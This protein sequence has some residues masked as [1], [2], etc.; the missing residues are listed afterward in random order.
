MTA[1]TG[2]TGAGKSIILGALG[3]VLGDRADRDVVRDGCERADI[4]AEFDIGAL[5]AALAWLDENTLSAAP[6]PAQCLIRRTVGADGRSRSWINNTPVTLQA[7]AALGEL[8]MDI[9]SQHEHHSLLKKAT[10]QQLLD[11][12]AGHSAQV[13]QLRELAIQWRDSHQRLQHLRDL[14]AEQAALNELARYQLNELEELQLGS[15][16]LESLEKELD[17]LAQADSRLA[18]I[19]SLLLICREQDD[20]N[21]RQQ[22]QQALHLLGQLT[23]HKKGE[24][25]TGVASQL[26]SVE[27]MLNTAL[28]QVEEAADEMSRLA[29][30]I[31]INPAR[32]EQLNRRL[33]DIH[34]LA[35]KHKVRPD[36]LAGL[37]HRLQ[38]QLASVSH[39]AD[40]M[41]HLELE[42][43]RLHTAW[44]GLAST[45]SQQ[46]QR[47]ADK[48]GTAVN[49]Q[50]QALAMGEASLTVH[51]QPNESN[52]PQAHGLEQ[53]EFLISTNRGQAARALSKIASGGELSRI[54]LAIQVITAMTS[55]IPCLVFDEVDV[56]IG[57]AVARTVGK[58]LRQLGERGQVL[59]VTHQALVAGQAHQHY[60]VSKAADG[61]SAHSQLIE[62]SNEQRTQE[63]ARMLGGET[64]QGS[65]S[66]ESMAHARELLSA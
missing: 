30:R 32:L 47:A 26:E 36:E 12:F 48:L 43:K 35:R 49:Q 57:G 60:R 5:P 34:Q 9:H 24:S 21:I 7:L 56:G 1:I 40:Q 13:R 29:D 62:L 46:R 51:L 66:D 25:K 8:L 18:G 27:D 37:Q 14:V 16:E 54:S 10:H 50:L 61:D 33:N 2:E 22:L 15:D 19:Q 45:L 23:H 39:N 58:L 55:Q 53:T 3:L 52:N 6:E 4:T 42:L 11:D 41:Q 65:I 28:I 38:D 63:I 59:C 31:D 44:S 17:E 20:G 64:E